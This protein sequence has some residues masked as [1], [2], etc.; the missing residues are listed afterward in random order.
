LKEKV[1]IIGKSKIALVSRILD[2]SVLP[3][4]F[5]AVARRVVFNTISDNGEIKWKTIVATNDLDSHTIGRM[6]KEICAFL[7]VMA[8]NDICYPLYREEDSEFS[9]LLA[10]PNTA[11]NK[12]FI[13]LASAKYAAFDGDTK[14]Y[15]IVPFA[16]A[17]MEDAVACLKGWIEYE[18]RPHFALIHELIWHPQSGDYEIL[19]TLLDAEEIKNML[20]REVRGYDWSKESFT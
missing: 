4:E 3:T 14:G 19:E 18:R 15:I 5:R 10:R 8:S 11:M 2:R 20:L 7:S 1:N 17:K 12:F 16:F 6:S 9:A 13:P